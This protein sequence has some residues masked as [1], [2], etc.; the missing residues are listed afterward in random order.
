MVSTVVRYFF[1]MPF[2]KVLLR[3]CCKKMK[4]GSKEEKVGDPRKSETKPEVK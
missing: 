4:L 1:H 3:V 2:L